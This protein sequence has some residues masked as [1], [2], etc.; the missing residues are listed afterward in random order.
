MNQIGIMQGRLTPSV[1]GRIQC[2]PRGN[3]QREF[4]LAAEAEF[5]CIEWLYDLHDADIN[6]IA[7]DNGISEIKGLCK[8]HA[9][10]VLSLCAH[11]F[12]EKPFL[13]SGKEAGG[14]FE[15]LA[16][17]LW[18]ASLLEIKRVV[19]PLEDASHIVEESFDGIVNIVEKILRIAEETNMEI[20]LETSLPPIQLANLLRRLPHPL[21][22][23]NYDSGNSAYLGYDVCDEFSAYGPRI[24]GVHIKD[25]TYHGN[26]VALGTGDVNFPILSDCL[27][28]IA[29]SGDFIFEVLPGMPGDELA[30]AKKNY[31]FLLKNIIRDR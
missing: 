23:V 15:I 21:L 2:F 31:A 4:S 6:P 14:R 10:K 18:R 20:D 17:L 19:L 5:D 25:K 28:S 11:C 12:I 13:E 27:R 3:W 29:Y 30:W 26:S 9:V 16:W 7:S 24:G 1:D 22:K 8:K